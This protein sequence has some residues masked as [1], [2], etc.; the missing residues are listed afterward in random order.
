M[1]SHIKRVTNYQ[2]DSKKVPFI[3]FGGY[4]LNDYGFTVGTD[5][6]VESKPGMLVI[7]TMGNLK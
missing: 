1:N 3:R 7:K 2:G 5:I 6:L 4:W